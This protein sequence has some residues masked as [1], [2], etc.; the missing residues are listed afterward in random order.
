MKECLKSLFNTICTCVYECLA[1]ELN[2]QYQNSIG[3]YKLVAVDAKTK[4]LGITNIVDVT[5][6]TNVRHNVVPSNKLKVYQVVRS[7]HIVS[8]HLRV[9]MDGI[10][11]H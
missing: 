9:V 7:I 2:T 6:Q 11:S 4:P 10:V 3:C 8:N 1:S 5:N